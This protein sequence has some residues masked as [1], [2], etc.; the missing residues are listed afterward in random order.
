[1][2]HLS[3]NMKHISKIKSISLILAGFGLGVVFSNLYPQS[4]KVDIQPKVSSAD[5]PLKCESKIIVKEVIVEVPVEKI[6]YR[7][8]VIDVLK[9]ENPILSDIGGSCQAKEPSTALIGNASEK[10]SNN[11]I[12]VK[13]DYGYSGKIELREINSNLYSVPVKEAMLGLE[14]QRRIKNDVWGSFGANVKGNV[15]LGIG[16]SF[17]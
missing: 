9:K 4:S 13:S 16:Y 14:Y 1:M 12:F 15:S 10:Q 11:I 5:S 6:V 3:L 7:K 17:K 2:H 8:K